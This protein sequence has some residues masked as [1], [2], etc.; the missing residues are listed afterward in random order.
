MSVPTGSLS[1]A[2]VITGL[3]P[4]GAERAMVRLVTGLPRP[5]FAP[6]VYSL[7][8]RPELGRD[9]LITELET[10]GVEVR[11]LDVASNWGCLSAT[12]HLARM[13]GEQR[14]DLVQTFL[15]HGNVFGAWAAHKAGIPRVVTGLRV[16]ERRG[17]WRLWLERW[18]ARWAMRHVAVSESVSQFARTSGGLKAERIVVIPNGVDVE[19]FRAATPARLEELGVPAGRK[20]VASIG[21]LD[22]QKGL[23]WL[24]E[25]APRWLGACPQHDLLIVGQ[26]PE[27]VRLERQAAG[28][29]IAPRVHFAG[30]REDIAGILKSSDLLVLSSAWEGMPNILLE[31]MAAGLPVVARQVEGVAEVLGEGTGARA[32]SSEVNNAQ[33]FCDKL[34]TILTHSELGRRLGLENQRRVAENFRWDQ[35]IGRYAELYRVL[36]R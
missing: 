4:G 25:S 14:A 15:L 6:R 7:L 12:H 24:L 33:D 23:N 18:A 9:L 36:A 29:G 17:R 16:A 22:P 5:E 35:M 1:V 13:L 20:V 3:E 10:A 2:F 26:G 11:F 8:P 31:A 30:W 34:V 28:L 21:R 32:Q 27:R 19:A